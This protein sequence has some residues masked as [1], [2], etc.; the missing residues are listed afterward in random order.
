MRAVGYFKKR[1]KE[2]MLFVAPLLLAVGVLAYV[3]HAV[4]EVSPLNPKTKALHDATANL[5]GFGCVPTAYE[6]TQVN[7]SLLARHMLGEQFLL[8][9]NN[10]V[11][12]KDLFDSDY[13]VICENR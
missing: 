12:H 10:V 5:A 9:L 2:V 7:E 3:G 13:V 6:K 4:Y 1:P 11:T 8:R